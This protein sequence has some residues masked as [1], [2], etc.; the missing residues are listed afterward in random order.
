MKI[1]ALITPCIIALMVSGFASKRQVETPVKP[2]GQIPTPT[3]YAECST[4]EHAI[5]SPLRNHTADEAKVVGK[6]QELVNTLIDSSCFE[7][8]FLA[9][10]LIQTESRT[11]KE[12]VDHIRS[13]KCFTIPV[14]MYS[15]W[16][17]K[18]VG[19]RQP[20]S[21]TIYTN[22]KFHAGANACDRA[23]NLFHEWLHSVGYGHDFK[24]TIRRPKSVPYSANAAVE[25]CCVCK[26]IM[27][28]KIK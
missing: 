14:E 10:D 27:D 1:K 8:F 16:W 5:F 21:L 11:N 6:S 4:K 23:S 20:P 9:R 15:A 17:S 24:A 3:P 12:V 18:V 13:Q 2:D 19:Y 28:C 7:Q 25:A 22:R 26:S